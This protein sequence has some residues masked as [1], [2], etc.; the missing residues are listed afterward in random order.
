VPATVTGIPEAQAAIQGVVDDARSMG[1]VHRLIAQAGEDAARNRAPKGA[2][3]NLSGSITGG[4]D[5]R[6]A[7]LAVGVAY[8][9]YQEFG[10]R[11]LRARRYMAAGIRAMRKVA[12]KEYRKKLGDGYK[13]RAKNARAAAKSR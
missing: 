3:G 6:Q 7:T 4:A 1:D 10:T 2:T 5:D 12:G 13:A 11:H 8:W 9:P